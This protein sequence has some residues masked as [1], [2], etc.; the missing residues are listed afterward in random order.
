MAAHTPAE[1]QQIAESL[2]GLR[3][4]RNWTGRG[5]PLGEIIDPGAGTRRITHWIWKPV[6][7]PA[8]VGLL[9]RARGWELAQYRAYQGCLAGHTIGETFGQAGRFLTFTGANATATN[10]ASQVSPEVS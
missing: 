8:L 2:G 4:I 7:E 1:R 5:E 3:F 6:R 10:G 9:P